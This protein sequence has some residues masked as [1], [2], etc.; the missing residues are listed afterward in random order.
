VKKSA[1]GKKKSAHLNEMK[2]YQRFISSLLTDCSAR[3]AGE[4]ACLPACPPSTG[5]CL[6]EGSF[7]GGLQQLSFS[8]VTWLLD[9]QRYLG[10]K[11]CR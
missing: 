11:I 6:A 3:A 8:C 5:M 7:H 9:Y 1:L 10:C 4:T 2:T